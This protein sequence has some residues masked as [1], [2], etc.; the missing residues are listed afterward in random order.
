MSDR[1]AS[2][3]LELGPDDEHAGHCRVCITAQLS[4]G[5]VLGVSMQRRLLPDALADAF[6]ALVTRIAL[7]GI[8][9]RNRE[10]PVAFVHEPVQSQVRGRSAL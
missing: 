1:V 3:A 4:Q 7:I 8:S 5:E 2:I 9:L 10:D 6:D